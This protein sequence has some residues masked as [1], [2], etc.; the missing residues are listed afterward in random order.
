LA[1]ASV[2]RAVGGAARFDAC[3]ARC[4]PEQHIRKLR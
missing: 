2:G 1:D 4:V 3:S